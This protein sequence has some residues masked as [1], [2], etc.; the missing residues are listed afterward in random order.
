MIH[1]FPLLRF[2]NITPEHVP[3][4]VDRIYRL[5]SKVGFNPLTSPPIYDESLWRGRMGL[6]KE[7]QR[8]LV[9]GGESED[10][11]ESPLSPHPSRE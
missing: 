5:W 10:Q 11:T 3:E 7:E 2:G 9:S 6:D 8:S 1:T 4:F